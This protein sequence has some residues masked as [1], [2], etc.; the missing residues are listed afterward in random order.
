MGYKIEMFDDKEGGRGTCL[1]YV[2]SAT[3]CQDIGI[4]G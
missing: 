3:E 2:Q 1:L 4:A